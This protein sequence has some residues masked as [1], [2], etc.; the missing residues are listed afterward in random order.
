MPFSNSVPP[1]FNYGWPPIDGNP[2]EDTIQI[3]LMHELPK[4]MS[5]LIRKTARS[6]SEEFTQS[7]ADGISPGPTVTGTNC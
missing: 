2:T 3:S 7:W 1:M 4:F 5:R 6:T